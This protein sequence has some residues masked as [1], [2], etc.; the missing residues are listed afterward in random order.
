LAPGQGNLAVLAGTGAFLGLLGQGKETSV[1]A[2]R[3]NVASV[4]EDPANRRIHG[5]R[6]SRFT[7][8]L[9]PMVRPEFVTSTNMPAVFHANFTPVTAS[10]RARRGGTLIAAATGLGPTIP[11]KQPDTLFPAETLREVAAPSRC[12]C[13]ELP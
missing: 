6:S 5:G 11:E 9:V 13:T 4:T 8:Q 12:W 10:N 7:F 1:A 2:G 3:R